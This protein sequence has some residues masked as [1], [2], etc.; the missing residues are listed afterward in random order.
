M[1][2]GIVAP[3]MPEVVAP[4]IPGMYYSPPAI[5]SHVHVPAIPA[6]PGIDSHATDDAA[7]FYFAPAHPALN[8]LVVHNLIIAYQADKASL[9]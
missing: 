6:R 3:Y 2:G 5:H 1:P 4:A 8:S 9:L 7:I